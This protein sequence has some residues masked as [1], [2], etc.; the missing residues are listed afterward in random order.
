MTGSELR[1]QSWA[2]AMNYLLAYG[3]NAPDPLVETRR[4]VVR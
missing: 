2:V 3:V 1:S 4:R